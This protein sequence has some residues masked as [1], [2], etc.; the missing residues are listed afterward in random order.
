MTRL[1]VMVV[2]GLCGVI[3][4]GTQ[5]AIGMCF[6]TPP[7]QVPQWQHEA[8]VK[9]ILVGACGAFFTAM[10]TAAKWLYPLVGNEQQF[11]EF[12]LATNAH[13]KLLRLTAI[14]ALLCGI[15]AGVWG[16]WFAR[17]A[18]IIGITLLPFAMLESYRAWRVERSYY[19]ARSTARRR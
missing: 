15:G 10:Y 14:G 12:C 2:S 13:L 8:E 4:G 5:F 7:G 18:L 17:P 16:G 1:A 6:T 9:L 19:D 11:R 3:A